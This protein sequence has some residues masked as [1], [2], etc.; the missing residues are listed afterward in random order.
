MPSRFE[1]AAMV[2]TDIGYFGDERLRK[3]GELL[4]ERITERQAVCLRKVG[5]DRAEHVKFR[6]F[7]LN[8]SVTVKEMVSHRAVLAAKAAVGR[9]VLAIQDTS[10]INYEAQRGRKRRLGTVGNGTDVGLFVHPV[11]GVDA[12]TEQCLGLFGAQIWRRRKGKAANYKRLPI[13]RK[14]S[15]RWL[16]A[17]TQAKAVLTQASMMTVMD[18]REGDIYEKWAR[19][20][21]DHTHL[22]TRA[23]QN[24][25][26]ADGGSLF[27][28]LAGF[29]EA[30]RYTLDLTAQPGKRS[31]R[32]ACI[33]V[34][35]GP[36]RIRRPASCSDPN[37]PAE[38]ELF[39]VEARE[40]DPPRGEKPICWRLLT[41]HKVESV[42][43]A[44]QVIGWYR[45]RWH[46]EQL[47]RTLKRQGLGIEQSVVEDGGALEKLAMI[48][49]IGAC[50]TMQLVLARTADGQD[51]PAERVF[52]DTEIEVLHGLQSKLQGRTSKQK[53]PYRPNSLA[54]A[55]WTIARLGGW[56]GYESERSTGPITMRDGLQR[57]NALVDGYRLAKNVCSS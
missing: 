34:R 56:T 31:A 22:L 21:D 17:P 51:A 16:K 29:P 42:A 44:L 38:I 46:I 48:A 50:I 52:D 47:F 49:L 26:L 1:E 39:A 37:A 18:D 53:N 4:V 36:V 33:A 43:Q 13:E 25:S 6:R 11:L 55:S 2:R 7:L 27:P 54:W 8:K 45:L 57:F 10:E 15:N 14:E 30:Y 40:L 41:T 23:S 5:D 20:P 9:H 28:T 19:L 12:D 3:V 32:Q 24:R 35:F